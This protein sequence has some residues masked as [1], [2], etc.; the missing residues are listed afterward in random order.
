MKRIV[1][2][3]NKA[4]FILLLSV[5]SFGACKKEAF[6]VSTTSD[7][8]MSEFLLQNPEQFSEFSKILQITGNEG[9]LGAYGN[10]TLFAPTN[11]AISAFV[12]SKGKSSVNDLDVN[13]LKDLVK[14][15]LIRDTIAAVLFNDG[16]LRTKTM[17]GQYLITGA[18]NI[19]GTTMVTINRQANLTQADIR[20]GN[21]IIHVIDHVLS[22]ARLTLAELIAQDE[23]YSLFKEALVVTGFYDSLNIHPED[24]LDTSKRYFTVLAESNE[25]LRASDPALTSIEALIDKYSNT[26]DPKLISDS[27]HL[28]VAY[29][30]LP[31]LKYMPDIFKASSH[32]TLS[33]LDVVTSKLQNTSVLI[34]DDTFNNIHEPGSE[35]NRT[36]SDVTA[37]NGVL[38]FM[39]DPYAIKVRFPIPVYWEV[40]DQPEITS[41]NGIFRVTNKSS[42]KFAPGDLKDINWEQGSLNM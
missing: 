2:Q 38:H 35:I 26:G 22:P 39:D 37:A 33:P 5:L 7:V 14:I 8:N 13:E 17:Y 31:G 11:D 42:Q 34:N 25:V 41:L 9:F 4:W 24:A 32:A 18:Q 16:K 21:G 19:N 1:N 6:K 12:S 15:H 20:V 29:H 23:N 10:Y 3:T 40:S 30:I 28:F 27:L 36:T